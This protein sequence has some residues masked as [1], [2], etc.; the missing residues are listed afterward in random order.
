[1]GKAMESALVLAFKK[2]P[3]THAYFSIY[4]ERQNSLMSETAMPENRVQS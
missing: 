3:Q 4:E 1:V 2:P